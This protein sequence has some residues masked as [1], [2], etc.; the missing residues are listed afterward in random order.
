[1][2]SQ[3]ISLLTSLLLVVG[4][5]D[6][7]VDVLGTNQSRWLLASTHGALETAGPVA[8]G[9][10]LADPLLLAPLLLLA[11][12]FVTQSL[13]QLRISQIK[14]VYSVMLVDFLTLL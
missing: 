8:E 7:R 14:H 5:V 1:M 6:C 11:H 4:V 2:Q 10:V 12:V 13:K 9:A 3:Y